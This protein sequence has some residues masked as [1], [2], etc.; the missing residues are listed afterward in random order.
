MFDR[1]QIAQ[2]LRFLA[3]AIEH[4]LVSGAIASA[5][6]ADLHQAADEIE[7]TDFV[8]TFKCDRQLTAFLVE[9]QIEDERDQNGRDRPPCIVG[10]F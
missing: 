1:T 10:L 7:S 2:W 5:V 4:G 9:R 3:E 6:P 8:E